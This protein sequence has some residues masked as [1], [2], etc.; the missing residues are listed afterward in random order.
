M[1]IIS[2]DFEKLQRAIKLP[3]LQNIKDVVQWSQDFNKQLTLLLSKSAYRM[4]DTMLQLVHE[5]QFEAN[6]TDYDVTNLDGDVDMEYFIIVKIVNQSGGAANYSIRLN[7]D[8]GTNYGFNEIHGSGGSAGS[9]EG[10]GQTALGIGK[11]SNDGRRSFFQGWMYAKSG[12]LR[13]LSGVHTRDI[14]GDDID[15]VRTEVGTWVN[16]TDKIT[17]LRFHSDAANGLGIGTRIEVWTR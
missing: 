9:S 10:T 15:E 11:S 8:S 5:K 4:N 16:T 7:N 14:N 1:P 12:D 17:S 13:Y 3:T 6:A 2:G